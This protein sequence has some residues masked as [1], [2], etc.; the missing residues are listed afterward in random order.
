MKIGTVLVDGKARLAV[1]SG[2]GAIVVPQSQALPADM[3]ALIKGGPAALELLRHAALGLLA[4]PMDDLHW[5]PPVERPG[6]VL[7][8]ALNNSANKSR[9]MKGPSHPAMFIKPTSSLIGHGQPVRLKPGYGRVHPEPELVVV[10]GSGGA[11]IAKADAM[12]HVFGYTIINDL[13][14]P[15]MRGEDT[16]HY[17]AIHPK[18]DGSAGIEYIDSWVSYPGRY[19]GTDTFGPIG[20]WIATVDE[21]PDPHQLTIRCLHKGELLTEDNTGNLTYKVADVVAF[22]SEYMTLEPGDL[23]AMGTALKAVDG[24]GV[25]AGRAVQ[26][27]DLTTMGGPIE[28]SISRIG[29][30]ANPVAQ[31]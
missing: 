25:K 18:A 13:T 7:C 26:N 17:R 4:S 10:I 6:K 5:L 2:D 23:I 11:D 21:V 1:S 12:S 14:A 20:P 29:S 30:L 9:I 31:R 3:I 24:D 19:K 22:A 15:I 8:V 16:F 28:V 27:I